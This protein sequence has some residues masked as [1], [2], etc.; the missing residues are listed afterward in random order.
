MVD[1]DPDQL[2]E[3]PARE[4]WVV[5]PGKHRNVDLAWEAMQDLIASGGIH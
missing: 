5:I 2:M 1:V 3:R 4:C